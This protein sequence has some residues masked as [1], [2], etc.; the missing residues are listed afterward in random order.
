MVPASSP[1]NQALD[2]SFTVQRRVA[3]WFIC[4]PKIQI[5]V[6]F[7][8]SWNEKC[9]Y[10]VCM[11]IWN[12]LWPFGK[13]YDL[14]EYSLC[15]IVSLSSIYF[16]AVCVLW[17][18]FLISVRLDQEKS[19]NPGP[20]P[21]L[22]VVNMSIIWNGILNLWITSHLKHWLAEVSSLNLKSLRGASSNLTNYFLKSFEF[23]LQ[24]RS[25]LGI[26][27]WSFF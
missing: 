10:I 19:G 4:I 6:Y 26:M 9:W 11:T 7:G 8:G 15:G 2:D 18:I 3:R 17:Y 24:T 12:I 20:V 21:F 16:T 1:C 5:C 14:L 25:Y 27:A 23:G 13:L 22:D